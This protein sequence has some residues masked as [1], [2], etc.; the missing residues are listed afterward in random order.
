MVANISLAS[1]RALTYT[2]LYNF[3]Q[4]GTYAITTDNIHPSYNHLQRIQEGYPQ[5]IIN[6]PTVEMAKMT[7]GPAGQ[8]EIPI[9]V[10]IDIYE[11]DSAGAKTVADEVTNKIFTGRSVL[12]DVGLKRIKFEG[13]S[14]DVE[15][16]SQIKTLHTYHLV[17]TAIY[18]GT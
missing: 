5:V 6:E 14:I 15:P 17:F 13:D 10:I 7:F 9:S 12:N 18:V 1:V 8:Y 16:Y 11:D 3:L 2:H 4:T